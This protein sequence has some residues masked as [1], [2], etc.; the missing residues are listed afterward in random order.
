MGLNAGIVE[1]ESVEDLVTE[2]TSGEACHGDSLNG[3]AVFWTTGPV[4]EES[5]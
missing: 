4:V 3:A 5:L 2:E 1:G